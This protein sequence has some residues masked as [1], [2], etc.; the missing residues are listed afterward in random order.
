M[1]VCLAL[2][3]VALASSVRGTIG[4]DRIRGTSGSD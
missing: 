4:K 2:S 3:A 1:V